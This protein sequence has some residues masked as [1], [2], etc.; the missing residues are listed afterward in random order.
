MAAKA[1]MVLSTTRHMK[2][3]D[4]NSPNSRPKNKHKKRDFKAYRGQGRP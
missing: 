4:G 3:S 1:K 2:T